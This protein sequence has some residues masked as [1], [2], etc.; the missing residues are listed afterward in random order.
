MG[1]K[2]LCE[3]PKNNAPVFNDEQRKLN[4]AEG[5]MCLK[6]VVSGPGSEVRERGRE[7]SK[8]KFQPKGSRFQHLARLVPCPCSLHFLMEMFMYG[9]NS[10][11]NVGLVLAH[12]K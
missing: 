1:E 6:V 2:T 9:K 5:N 8:N 12:T 11:F 10:N 3:R 7:N 4:K